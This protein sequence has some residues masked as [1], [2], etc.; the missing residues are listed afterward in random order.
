MERTRAQTWPAAQW[1]SNTN[2]AGETRLM[3]GHWGHAGVSQWTE[4]SRLSLPLQLCLS[5]KNKMILY[6]QMAPLFLCVSCTHEAWTS[7][8]GQPCHPWVSSPCATSWV[9]AGFA[10]VPCYVTDSGSVPPLLP[11][12]ILPSITEVLP[13]AA[14]VLPKTRSLIWVFEERLCHMTIPLLSLVPLGLASSLHALWGSLLHQLP[15]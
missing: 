10:W 5:N 9:H 4:V 3:S 12:R 6:K 2:A 14:H 11:I 7:G 1:R 8:S 15:S 13:F